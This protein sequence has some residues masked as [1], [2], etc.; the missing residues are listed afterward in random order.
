MSPCI[1]A[2]SPTVKLPF[3]LTSCPAKIDLPRTIFP[4][5]LMSFPICSDPPIFIK[6]PRLTS[7]NISKLCSTYA[8]PIIVVSSPINAVP[9]NETSVFIEILLFDC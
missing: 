2:F 4:F 3:I 8:L 6:F 7:C 1:V 5:I 9:E